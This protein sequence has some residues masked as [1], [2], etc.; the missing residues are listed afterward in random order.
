MVSTRRKFLNSLG[1]GAGAFF[2]NPFVSRIVAEAQGAPTTTKRLVLFTQ[3]NGMDTYAQALREN[4]PID[5]PL[6][7]TIFEPLEKYKSKLLVIG[8][9]YNPHERALHGNQYASLT[10]MPSTN[11]NVG[12]RR[13][14][15]GGISIDRKIAH[16]IGAKD[17]FVSVITGLREGGGTPCTSADGADKL[18]PAIAGP[19][20]VYETYL[21]GRGQAGGTGF[22]LAKDKSLIDYVRGD[23]MRTS[24]RLAPLEREK[25][26][27]YVDSLRLIETQLQTRTDALNGMGCH[28]PE[29]PVPPIGKGGKPDQ[30]FLEGHPNDVTIKTQVDV[31]ATAL[32]CGLTK[33][34]HLS[35]LGR[36]AP[37]IG[38]GW[39]PGVSMNHHQAS[40]A[41]HD[42]TLRAMETY[43]MYLMSRMADHLA[44]TPEGNGTM[45]DNTVIVY[46]NV[47]GGRDHGGQSHLHI[48]SVGDAGGYFKTG[49]M[50]TRLTSAR[51]VPG[52]GKYAFNQQKHCISDYFVSLANAMGVNIDTFGD[53]MHCKGPLPGIS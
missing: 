38:F 25:L 8:Q 43:S 52:D 19:L 39:L 20:D 46:L 37:H 34:A 51:N 31:A 3:G 47:C 7:G 2:L 53:P 5:F 21:G 35:I 41:N 33:V 29:K 10:V 30:R 26:D 45:L 6:K 9:M 24:R 36:E 1:L 42:P 14:P 15:P 12:E 32:K 40:H 49:R 23:I 50:M 13:G 28:L 22:D 11:P 44:A 48:I 17:A 16:A 27:Q 18:V 4:S